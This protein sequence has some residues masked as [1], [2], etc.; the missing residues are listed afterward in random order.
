VPSIHAT[1]HFLEKEKQ[2]MSLYEQLRTTRLRLHRLLAAVIIVGLLGIPSAVF[3][4][5]VPADPDGGEAAPGLFL[6]LVTSDDGFNQFMMMDNASEAAYALE[7]AGADAKGK[8]IFFASDGLRQD[9]IEQFAREPWTMP[10][11]RRLLNTGV[12]AA[13]HPQP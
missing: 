11:M 4:Q 8:A 9:I 3:A 7:E 10:F 1:L 6:P 5:D 2:A 12:K 13:R